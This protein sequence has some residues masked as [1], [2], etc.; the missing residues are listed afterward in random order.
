M[1]TLRMSGLAFIVILLSGSFTSCSKGENPENDGDYSN[2]KKLVRFVDT[3]GEES[4]TYTF[5]YDEKGRL[6]KAE[7]IQEY[8]STNIITN[9]TY[10]YEFTWHNDGITTTW[11]SS[12]SPE[13]YSCTLS[14]NNGL[15]LR[16][17]NNDYTANY[18]YNSENRLVKFSDGE[19]WTSTLNWDGD[20]LKSMSV[21]EENYTFAY[22][23]SCM[24]GYSAIIPYVVS[25]GECGLL[26]M[27]HPE[28]AGMR[29]KQLPASVN[30]QTFSYEY[31]KEGY[32]SKIVLE[33]SIYTLTWK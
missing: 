9:Y 26:F 3:S 16:E 5:S 30:G 10:S 17:G 21:G 27:A 19:Y 29:T 18:T 4:Y 14:L 20:K 25:P 31:D 15:V 7:S 6:T 22:N 11:T 32:V 28:L 13:H 1:K 8:R 24:K 12:G 23:E 2:E 33:D